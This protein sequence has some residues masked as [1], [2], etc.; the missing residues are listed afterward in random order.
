MKG[1]VALIV[2]ATLLVGAPAAHAHLMN[3]GFGPFYDG[4]VHP[5]VTAED[6]LPVVAL[7]LLAGLGGADHGRR[8]LLTLTLA[9]ALGMVAAAVAPGTVEPAWWPTILTI[10]LG[11]LVAV[12][13]AWSPGVV[14]VLASATGSSRGYGNGHELSTVPGGAVAMAGILCATFVVFSLLAG[15]VATVRAPWAR[16]A[17]RV[18]GS[19]I[20]AIGL[21][22]LGWAVRGR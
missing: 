21:L 9:W 18:A 11:V 10:L 15:H 3:S 1:S 8:G 22:M 16:I 7:G 20:A 13:R 14:V 2:A 6:L 17:V 5:F 19:W 12:D 4:L